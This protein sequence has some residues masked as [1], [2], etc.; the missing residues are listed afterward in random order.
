M[1]RSQD[2]GVS[3]YC[4]EVAVVDDEDFLEWAGDLLFFFPIHA[5]RF[6]L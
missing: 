3:V 1:I 6:M 5:D 2:P 4:I